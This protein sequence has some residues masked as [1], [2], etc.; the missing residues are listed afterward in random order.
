MTTDDAGQK[1][2]HSAD[3]RTFQIQSVEV[4]VVV[5]IYFPS[6]CF[7]TRDGQDR[8]DTMSDGR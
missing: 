8:D 7:Q 1:E 4:L 6:F 3:Y 5:V 2:W